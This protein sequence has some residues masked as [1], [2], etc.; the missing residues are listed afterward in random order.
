[1]QVIVEECRGEVVCCADGV[2][3]TGE[4]QVELLHRNHLAVAATCSAALDA[5]NRSETWLSNRDGGAVANL[6]EALRESD[7]GG[8]LPFTEWRWANCGDHHVLAARAALL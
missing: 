2:H 6:V 1:M 4:V 3:I 5:E 8:G 7:G